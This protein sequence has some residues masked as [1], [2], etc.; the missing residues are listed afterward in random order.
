MGVVLATAGCGYYVTVERGDTLS[1]I[2][3]EYGLTVNDLLEANPSIDDPDRIV[4]GEKIRVPRDKSYRFS[5]T[6]QQAKK[7][8]KPPRPEGEKKG[9]EGR[10]KTSS[11]PDQPQPTPRQDPTSKTP[12][13]V[14]AGSVRFIWPT[15]GTILRNFGKG[16]DGRLNEGIDIAAN[17]GAKVLAAADGEVIMSGTPLKGYGNM[18]VVQHAGQYV[19]I[20]AH[21]RVNLVEKG[22]KVKQGDVIAEVGDTGRANVPHLHFEV[23]YKLETI[24]PLTVLP[25]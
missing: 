9:G 2:S 10:S 6:S 17:V 25:R 13:P 19:T 23:R 24:D 3:R 4:V 15:Q 12:A 7:S 14:P 22:R 21:N 20:Y 5:A 18:V 8:E 1:G 16:P 11:K